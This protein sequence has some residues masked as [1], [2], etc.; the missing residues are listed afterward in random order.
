[1]YG[2][3]MLRDELERAIGDVLRQQPL[4]LAA[5]TEGPQD[6]AGIKAQAFEAVVA[7][8]GALLTTAQVWDSLQAN[9]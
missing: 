4:A 1:M 8:R 9:D 3:Q 7:A 2:R 5:A 6:I